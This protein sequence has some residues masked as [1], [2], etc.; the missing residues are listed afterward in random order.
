MKPHSIRNKETPDKYPHGGG[1]HAGK[2]QPV[3]GG[4]V[5]SG[6]DH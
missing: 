5:L 3:T 2:S 1:G 6:R 4:T